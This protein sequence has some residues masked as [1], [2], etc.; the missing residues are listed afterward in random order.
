MSDLTMLIIA[1]IAWVPLTAIGF[2]MAGKSKGYLEGR[3][4]SLSERLVDQKQD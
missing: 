2:Y 3:R 1:F 4:V